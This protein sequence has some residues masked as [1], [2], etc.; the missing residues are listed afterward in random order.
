MVRSSAT[1]PPLPRQPAWPARTLFPEDATIEE[2]QFPPVSPKL[3]EK[4]LSIAGDD[5]FAVLDLPHDANDTQVQEAFYQLLDTF[6]LHDVR[7]TYPSAKDVELA[8]HLFDRATLAYQTLSDEQRRNAYLED[9]AFDRASKRKQDPRILADAA[10]LRGELALGAGR[11]EEAIRHLWV[12]IDNYEMDPGYFH[13]LG[14]AGYLKALEETPPDE[15]IPEELAKP[16]ERALA[17]DPAYDPARFYLGNIAKRNGELGIAK[18]EFVATL[19]IN[20]RNRQAKAALKEVQQR[21]ME[22]DSSS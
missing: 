13:K 20:P 8:G 12:A 1:P 22:R 19:R 17:L 14:L 9:L 16:F 18:T 5:H 7:A 21:I 3:A 6:K 15:P 2:S 4:V 10:A 11:Y